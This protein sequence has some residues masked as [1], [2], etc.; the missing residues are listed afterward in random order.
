[1]KKFL[2]LLFVVNALILSCSADIYYKNPQIITRP[3]HNRAFGKKII[4]APPTYINNSANISMMEQALFHKNY[5]GENLNTRLT[6]LE[7]NLFGKSVNGT[8]S[9]RYRNLSNAFDYSCPNP[10]HSHNLN[11]NYRYSNL[12]PYSYE[13]SQKLGIINRLANFLGGT[14]TGLT[15]SMNDYGFQDSYQTP[16]G[17]GFYNQNRGTGMSVRILD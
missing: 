13:T 10:Y 4:Q 8:I 3:H 2:L 17:Y 11:N 7:E 1:M 9:D 14:A 6:R 15:P 16:Y 5:N 12:P